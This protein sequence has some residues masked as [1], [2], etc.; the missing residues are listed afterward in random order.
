MC[1]RSNRATE[2]NR[3]P[4]D[5][6]KGTFAIQFDHL[7]I[8]TSF[9]VKMAEALSESVSAEHETEQNEETKPSSFKE[10]MKCYLGT[11]FKASPFHLLYKCSVSG[12]SKRRTYFYGGFLLP[13]FRRTF[14]FDGRLRTPHVH[15][16]RISSGNPFASLVKKCIS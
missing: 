11:K 5:A 6:A 10:S 4:N 16:L 7:V 3:L 15:P 9:F 12:R 1:D 13:R 2:R 8:Q 14:N